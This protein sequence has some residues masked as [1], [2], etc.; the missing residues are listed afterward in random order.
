MSPVK[1]N[2][3]SGYRAGFES[4]NYPD[5]QRVAAQVRRIKACAPFVCSPEPERLLN[6]FLTSHNIADLIACERHL[7]GVR[8]RLQEAS[9]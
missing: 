4:F 6:G 3:A 2:G 1:R 8:E 5:C 7:T 9:L